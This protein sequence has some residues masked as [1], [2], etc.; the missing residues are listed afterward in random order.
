MAQTGDTPLPPRRRRWLYVALVLLLVI[1]GVGAWASLRVRADEDRLAAMV[2]VIR[3]RGEPLDWAE[4]APEPVPP[5]QNAA[6]L[7]L[8]AVTCYERAFRLGSGRGG[9]EAEGSGL[10]ELYRLL[11]DDPASHVRLRAKRAGEVRQVLS[12]CRD[13]LPLCRRARA[14]GAA[15]WR[16]SYVG[17]ACYC[18]PPAWTRL[19]SV[20][21]V[22]CLAAVTAAEDSN[23]P[24]AV[25]S[26]R[27]ALHLAR[28]LEA[29]PHLAFFHTGAQVRQG[30]CTS[31]EQLAPTLPVGRGAPDTRRRTGR[32]IEELL[33]PDRFEWA[34]LGERSMVYD[35]AE[36]MR[37]GQLSLSMMK[38]PPGGVLRG[39][40]DFR[41]AEAFPALYVSDEI[42]LLARLNR[43]VHA[44]K[45]QTFP[46]AT[47][48]RKIRL[49]GYVPE[50]SGP[51][52]QLLMPRLAS[53]HEERFRTMALCRLA[54]TALAI[55]QYELDLGRR[56][57]ALAELV[58]EY[59]PAVPADPFAADERAV[60]FAPGRA[61]PVLY[62]LFKDGRDDGGA[63]GTEKGYVLL[64]IS[65]DLVLFLNGDRPD[66]ESSPQPYRIVPRALPGN[67]AAPKAAPRSV[68]GTAGG[69]PPN[70]T[71][72]G[73]A[74]R[75]AVDDLGPRENNASPSE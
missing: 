31:I 37:A 13:I 49:P 41:L 21:N 23:A 45:A 30:V 19:R 58:P 59:L 27:D 67:T 33:A 55:R 1:G 42:E 62:S 51:L 64:R 52:A 39:V 40:R 71:G 32:L 75:G 7:Y 50:N 56:P 2:G 14:C 20:G 66:G 69:S 68:I 47:R 16:L 17:P 46:E 26:L 8:Q 44:G 4:F 36:R 9:V 10:G 3:A 25:E 60:G 48:R 65:P 63:Y 6:D 54:A 22:L 18:R 72:A 70:R 73:I 15:D 43:Q 29:I 24:E 12:L 34:V 11:R 28:G 5:E 74:F 35:T 57:N 53:L 38:A 61:S